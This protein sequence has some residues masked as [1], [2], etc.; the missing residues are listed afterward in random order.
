MSTNVFFFFFFWTNIVSNRLY[1]SYHDGQLFGRGKQCRVIGQD[2]YSVKYQPLA[3]LPPTLLHAGRVRV[4]YNNPHQSTKY[5]CIISIPTFFNNFY[6]FKCVFIEV[7]AFVY[8]FQNHGNWLVLRHHGIFYQKTVCAE[9]CV[10]AQLVMSELYL[11]GER[12]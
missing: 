5:V 10:G 6:H 4:G 8:I 7:F 2:F 12:L 11:L 9:K 3:S 1:R